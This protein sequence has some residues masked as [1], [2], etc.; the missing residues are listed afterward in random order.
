MTKLILLAL[1]STTL[2]FASTSTTS[3]DDSLNTPWSFEASITAQTIEDSKSPSVGATALYS[4]S[5]KFDLGLRALTSLSGNK[6]ETG[7]SLQFV[8]R[9]NFYKSKTDLFVELNQGYAED[10]SNDYTI[11]G[12][13]LGLKH[14]LSNEIHFGGIAGADKVLSKSGISPKIATFIA[15]T[16]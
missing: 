10:F 7:H 12:S 16:I 15:I 4:I 6:F 8:Q 2:S 9:Y 1:A 14:M 5:N 3:V 11:I 13:S